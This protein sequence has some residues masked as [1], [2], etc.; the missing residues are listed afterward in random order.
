V[1]KSILVK[2]EFQAAVLPEVQGEGLA[3]EAEFFGWYHVTGSQDSLL[4]SL[5]PSLVLSQSGLYL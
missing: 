2:I 4:H 1:K 3:L 5:V